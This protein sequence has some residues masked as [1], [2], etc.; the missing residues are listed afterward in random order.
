[1]IIRG[2]C[3]NE[4]RVSIKLAQIDLDKL[5]KKTNRTGLQDYQ[6][7]LFISEYFEKYHP[8]IDLVK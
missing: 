3:E 7:S 8:R 5:Q 4:D 6:D 1:M 2:T